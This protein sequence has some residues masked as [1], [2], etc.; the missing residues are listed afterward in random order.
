MAASQPACREAGQRSR[1]RYLTSKHSLGFCKASLCLNVQLIRN[2]YIAD[3]CVPIIYSML[4]LLL[5]FEQIGSIEK[6]ANIFRIK[7]NGLVKG[8]G[9]EMSYHV[10]N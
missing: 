10:L 2:R 1:L 6:C 8:G 7:R 3:C 4:P 9:A 5:L